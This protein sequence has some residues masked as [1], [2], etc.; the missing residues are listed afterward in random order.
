M[1]QR[2]PIAQAIALLF[3][4]FAVMP[5]SAQQ[6]DDKTTSNT[7]QN[8]TQRVEVTGSRIKRVDAETASAVQVISKEEIIRSG[9]VTLTDVL[10]T[11]PAG[12][13][14]GYNTEGPPTQAFGA[15]GISLRG[16][17]VGSTLVLVNGRR[18]APYG[19]GTAS[20]VD[21][22]SIPVDAIE[23]IE[24]LLDG[25][26]AIY[27]ADAIAGVINIILRKDYQGKEVYG[28][29]GTSGYRD[30]KSRSAGISW[31]QGNLAQDGYNWMINYGHHEQDPVLA[32]A[33]P[34][35]KDADFR[36]F[37]LTD[38]RS[39]FY[40]N[41]YQTGGYYG[42][43]F[44]APLAG[45]IP[46]NDPAT[47][48]LNGRCVL[49]NTKN[50]NVVSASTNDA[51]YAT[52]NLAL[53]SD[54]QLFSDASF[55]R[56]K[57]A[58]NTYSYGTSAYAAYTYDLVDVKGEFGNAP[59]SPIAYLVLPVGHPQNPLKDKPVA[60][61]YNFDDIQNRIH[62]ANDNSRL[63]LGIRGN[64][65]EWDTEIGVMVAKAKG[66]IR[67]RGYIQ[68]AVLTGEVLDKNGYV[69]KSFILGDAAAN[70]AALMARLYP[71]MRNV[72]DTST[73][74]IDVKASRE[75]WQLPGG[76]VG[77][78]VG[79]EFRQEKF[80]SVPDDLFSSGAIQLFS[81]TGSVGQRNVAAMY[82]EIV[83]PVL[84]ELELNAAAR[85]DR[86]NDFGAATTPK[87]GIKWKV[88]PQ[89][90]VRSTFAHGF[91]AP[92]LPEMNSGTIAG[93]MKVQDPKFC[94]TLSSDNPQCDRYVQYEIGQNPNL[95]AEKS[96]SYTLGTV[97]EP[98]TGWSL[99]LDYYAIQRRDEVSQISAKYLLDHESA[100][101][102]LVIRHAGTNVID[103][104]LL[105][106][107]NLA[108]TEVRGI[109]LDARGE[110][111]M[112]DYGK[113]RLNASLNKVLSY[114]SAENSSVDKVD[115][116][117]YYTVPKNRARF[118]LGWEQGNMNMGFSWNYVAGYSLKAT[119]ESNCTYQEK[120]P[121]YCQIKPWLTTDAYLTYR[122]QKNLN[123][124]LTVQ[125]L[126]NKEAPFDASMIAY[127]QGF[128]AAFH[129][130]LGR[131]VQISAKYS[132]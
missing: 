129:N 97:I 106:T 57:Y 105:L 54:W 15:A 68:D 103:K 91:R 111:N 96:K 53:G 87:L 23:R 1:L 98:T 8:A 51:V 60:V 55:S 122:Y 6:S 89:W 80:S 127:L 76:R 71:A 123:L 45:C 31:G 70:D 42:G 62:S 39:S 101:P 108:Q 85:V 59:G 25:A 7:N 118:G 29:L 35:T 92:T 11:I 74:L 28:S 124:S 9:A 21:T 93:Y 125:N 84:K 64:L 90:A 95:K 117:G 37:N 116:A 72:S 43:S 115:Y 2:R 78:S 13:A 112:A 102:N 50:V 36:R 24:T 107:S 110:V 131:F 48:A 113:L 12:N 22:N 75:L 19:F 61:R 109:D 81:I 20:F 67:Y 5:V 33:R 32:N 121:S 94:P 40:R 88:L 83:A 16:L 99:A 26:S 77:V 73:A 58:A 30:A 34:R 18:T 130:Q 14:G 63:T 69:N 44:I 27:G 10:R 66:A 100:Y 120:N 86:Y 132:F 82:G 46:V 128:N 119:P 104:L 65:G 52:A 3:S 114:K 41:V 126:A 38:S 4:G 17:G 79:G 56:V 47:P 49:D